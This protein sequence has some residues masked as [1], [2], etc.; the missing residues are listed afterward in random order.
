MRTR[1]RVGCFGNDGL[2]VKQIP[3]RG[4]QLGE[5]GAMDVNRIFGLKT[6]TN[7][8]GSF[9]ERIDIERSATPAVQITY[10]T[11]G[12]SVPSKLPLAILTWHAIVGLIAVKRGLLQAICILITL[13]IRAS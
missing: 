6:H 10:Y 13:I 1:A 3:D 12:A 2:E 4:R 7:E 11:G 8:H 9:L 5:K